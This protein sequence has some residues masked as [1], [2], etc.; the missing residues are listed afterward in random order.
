MTDDP[1]RAP[2]EDEE[3]RFDRG[4]R[5]LVEVNG[6][7]G[8]EIVLALGDLGRYIFEF[9]YG[10]IY[11]R[12]GLSLRERAIATLSILLAV[13]GRGPQLRVHFGSALNVGLTAQEIEEVILQSVPYNGFPAAMDAISLLREVMDARSA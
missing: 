2:T 7:V 3:T 12:D 1:I 4:L 11:T 9:A 6:P 10:D 8:E 5:R 13:P